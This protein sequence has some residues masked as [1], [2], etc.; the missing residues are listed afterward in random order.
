M[1]CASFMFGKYHFLACIYT[2]NNTGPIRTDTG[3]NPGPAVSIDQLK[4][5][6]PDLMSQF[7]VKLKCVKIGP[8]KSW[9]TTTVM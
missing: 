9:C 7:L 5:D 6:Q 2:I 1:I 3:E 8:P 4:S